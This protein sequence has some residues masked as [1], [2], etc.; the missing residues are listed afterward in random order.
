MSRGKGYYS[1]EQK[2][3]LKDIGKRIKYLRKK[4]GVSQTELIT[5]IEMSKQGLSKIENGR[6]DVQIITLF[7]ITKGIGCSMAE[8]FD[9]EFTYEGQDE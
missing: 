7:E 4:Y 5:R 6:S 9:F 2:E 1:I 8:L 3:Y